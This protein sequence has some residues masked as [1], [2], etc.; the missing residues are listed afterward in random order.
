M[1]YRIR[2][3]LIVFLI[4]IQV[5]LLLFIS[6]L[7]NLIVP[8]T[9]FYPT[10]TTEHIV[11]QIFAHYTMTFASTRSMSIANIA[12][13]NYLAI[14]RKQ[15]HKPT[16]CIQG[17]NYSTPVSKLIKFVESKMKYT[18]CRILNYGIQITI[19]TAAEDLYRHS[20]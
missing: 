12:L 9:M 17:S 20:F 19:T 16:K 7:S 4:L 11:S 14:L 2:A 8:F 15:Q 10:L 13:S 18:A 5:V 3:I 6:Q 1:N